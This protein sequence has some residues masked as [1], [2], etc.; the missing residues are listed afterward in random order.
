MHLD[1]HTSILLLLD[2]TTSHPE[3]KEAFD[4]VVVGDAE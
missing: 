3:A 2:P 4:T 1:T